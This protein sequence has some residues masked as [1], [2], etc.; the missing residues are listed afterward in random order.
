[1]IGIDEVGRGPLAGPVTLGIVVCEVNL[2]KKLKK[3]RNLPVI[4]KDSKKLKPEERE[5]YHNYLKNLLSK[6][7]FGT[8]RGR[9]SVD[10][11][12]EV[13]HVSNVN[14]DKIGISKC[15]KR[16]I[17]TGLNKIA[18]DFGLKLDDLASKS[19]IKL[20][21]GLHMPK[22]FESKFYKWSTIIKGDEKEKIIAWA[23]ILAKVERDNLMKKASKKYPEYGFEKHVGYG[24]KYHREMIKIKGISE[25]HRVSFCKNLIKA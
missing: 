1:M 21:G 18:R 23:S 10:F 22:D 11:R 7:P 25:F 4:G 19:E 3:D 24:T 12:Y 13:I 20:D 15:I 8:Y 16:A 9:A 17:E 2:Y 5:K 6:V 14:I